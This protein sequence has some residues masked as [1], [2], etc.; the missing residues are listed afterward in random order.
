MIS[1]IIKYW[2]EFLFGIVTSLIMVKFKN[3]KDDYEM[4][5]ETKNSIC[6]LIK[7][8]IIIEYYDI[9]YKKYVT[10]YDKEIINDLYKEYKNLGG[11]GFVENLIKDINSVPVKEC[12]GD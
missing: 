3:F 9:Q 12:G 5:K 6:I 8:E 7:N 4:I 11:N 10:I 1:F 2:I